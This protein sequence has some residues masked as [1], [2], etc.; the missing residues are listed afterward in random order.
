MRH[1]HLSKAAH[2]QQRDHGGDGIAHQHTG[3]GDSDG[4]GA[5]EK[6]SRTDG[7]ADRDHG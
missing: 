3:A 4:E 1:R 2:E 7:S 5:A 6:Q